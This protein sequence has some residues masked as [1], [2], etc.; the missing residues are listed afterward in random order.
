MNKFLKVKCPQCKLIF[1]YYDSLS[2]PFCSERCKMIDLGHWFEE[3]Y[4]VPVKGQVNENETQDENSNEY[5]NEYE[6]ESQITEESSEEDNSE[7][8]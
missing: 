4:R 6:E 1:S 5:P 7:Y 2:R 8:N 3:S